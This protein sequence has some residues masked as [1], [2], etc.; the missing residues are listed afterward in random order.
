MAETDEP[1][2]DDVHVGLLLIHKN[3]SGTF[4]CPKTVVVVLGGKRILEFVTFDDAFIVVFALIYT[5]NLDYPS[6]LANTFEF[7]QK[8]LIG[9]DDG[10]LKSKILTLK[11]AILSGE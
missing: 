6:E 9:L 8:V 3:S 11:N 5:L 7:V 2:V 10:R 1:N 4:L